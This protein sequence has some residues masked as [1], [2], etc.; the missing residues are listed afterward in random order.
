MT[1]T[2]IAAVGKNRE[3]GKRNAL[4]WRLPGDLPFF[5][6]TTM[7]HPV[8]MGRK[9]FESLPKALPGRRNIVVTRN[10]HFEA[11]GAEVA[12]SPEA[13]LKLCEGEDE[14]FV[15][16]GGSVYRAF[17]PLADRLILTEAAATDPDADAFFPPFDP[18]GYDRTVLDEVDGDV[19]YVRALYQKKERLTARP[20]RA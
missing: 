18:D 6:A 4:I 10:P 20:S 2:L 19:P 5:K 17:L 1:V 7:G 16:G 15:I 11:P 9:T 12:P 13:A 14:V 3:I 8:V